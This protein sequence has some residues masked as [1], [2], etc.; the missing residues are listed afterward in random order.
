MEESG[1]QRLEMKEWEAVGGWI[2]RI[3]QRKN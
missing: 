2:T 3:Y 1:E